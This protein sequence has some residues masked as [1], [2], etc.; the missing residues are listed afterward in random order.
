ME[1]LEWQFQEI[2]EYRCFQDVHANHIMV[3][4]WLTKFINC[5]KQIKS[6][7]RF[8]QCMYIYWN[9]WP[10]QIIVLVGQKYY[11]FLNTFDWHFVYG[12]CV[13]GQVSLTWIIV[14]NGWTWFWIVWCGT[15]CLVK[16]KEKHVVLFKT[17]C[18]II[19]IMVYSITWISNL[20]DI[21]TYGR[22][23]T[24]ANFIVLCHFIKHTV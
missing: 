14:V 5:C 1:Q 20:D 22:V 3:Y 23:Q 4:H 9:I 21:E 12:H 17:S 10:S 7:N 16:N 8:K 18:V 6:D 15:A 13:S 11:S 2:I 19:L 24:L